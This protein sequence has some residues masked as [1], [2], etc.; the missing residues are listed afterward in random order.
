MNKHNIHMSSVGIT[1]WLFLIMTNIYIVGEKIHATNCLMIILQS[2][3]N[4]LRW[5][6]TIASIFELAIMEFTIH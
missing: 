4:L 6:T 1:R 3:I 5:S 2:F